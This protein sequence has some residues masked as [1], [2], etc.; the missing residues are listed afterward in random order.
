M[1]MVVGVS[2]CKLSK[3]AEDVLA[4]YALGSCIAVGLH[5]PVAGVGG[6]LHFMLPDS[7][8]D[9]AKAGQ[10]PCMFADT[11]M[12]LLLRQALQ[13]GADRRRMKV[14]AAGGAQ[15]VDDKGVFEIGRRNSLALRKLL[16]KA[17]LLLAGEAVGGAMHRNVRL[18][19]GPGRFWCRAGSQTERLLAA[20]DKEAG[21]GI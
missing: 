14:W 3:N 7:S 5:D 21:H 15:M 8:L 9:R 2:D 6:L 17:G 12:A 10:N 13:L 1:L 20:G 4:T 16:W 19:V 18:E 11:G